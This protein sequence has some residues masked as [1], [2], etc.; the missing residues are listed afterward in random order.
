MYEAIHYPI[1]RNSIK[2]FK[3]KSIDVQETINDIL[4]YIANT[5][6]KEVKSIDSKKSKIFDFSPNGKFKDRNLLIFLNKEFSTFINAINWMNEILREIGLIY[7]E[8]KQALPQE[9]EYILDF[10]LDILPLD[11]K[12]QLKI[13]KC[14]FSSLKE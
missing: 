3:Y 13:H 4:T 9:E 10:E 14:T 2:F 1:V 7:T 5:I 8:G 12:N 6:Q 11:F